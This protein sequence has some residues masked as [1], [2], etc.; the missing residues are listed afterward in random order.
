MKRGFGS[1]GEDSAR[2]TRFRVPRTLGSN[3]DSARL[4]SSRQAL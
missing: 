1:R 4:K 2:S 3:D